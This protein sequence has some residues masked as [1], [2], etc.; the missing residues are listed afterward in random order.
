MTDDTADAIQTLASREI[1]R[2]RWLA[3]REDHI[4]RPDGSEGLYSV[5][6][7]TD[8]V[9]VVPLHADGSLTL[10]RQ[11][12]HPIGRQSWEFPMGAWEQTPD[13]AKLDV[14]H[15]ELREETGLTAEHMTH[16]GRLAEAAGYCDQWYDI[17]LAEGLQQHDPQRETEE[18]DMICRKVTLPELETM[19][20]SGEII[21]AATVASLCLL[22]LRGLLG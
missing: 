16:A 7:K 8:F 19:I 5:V 17:Y 2:N 3:L 10:V 21:D 1:Y 9:V 15:G 22:R 11:H 14:A 12:R 4:R 13:A 6:E 20:L 18:A